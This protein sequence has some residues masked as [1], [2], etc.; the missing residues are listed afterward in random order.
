ML[1]DVCISIFIIMEIANVTTLYFN[2]D[3]KLFNGMGAFKIWDKIKDDEQYGDFARYLVNWVAGTKL[4]FI[5]LLTV[6]LFFGS[7]QV[8]VISSGAMVLSIASFFWRLFPIIRRIDLE[9][10]IDPQNYHKTL[11][12][13]IVSFMGM[14]LAALVIGII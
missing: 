7:D 9:G 8:K 10:M 12:I 13:M 6:I 14:F 4:I 3:T 5:A 2:P 11:A 1:L